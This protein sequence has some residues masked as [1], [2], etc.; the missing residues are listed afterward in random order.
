M[1][2]LF[3]DAP[4]FFFEVVKKS[5]INY[6][7]RQENLLAW[8][9]VLN[10]THY[11]P[12]HY[13]CALIDFYLAYQNGQAVECVD[14][15]FILEHNS[16]LCAV[17]PLSLSL[18]NQSIIISSHG[19]AIMPPLFTKDLPRKLQK[20]LVKMCQKVLVEFCHAV[21]ISGWKSAES[22]SG[23][24]NPALSEW[25]TQS[26]NLSVDISLGYDMFIDLADNI[27][28]IKSGFR[29][30]YK[31]LI[32]SG[33]RIWDISVVTQE[34]SKVWDEFQAF[35]V[36]VAGKETRC[37]QSWDV[38]H[39]A[40]VDNDAFLV[41]LR[42][43]EGMMVGAGFFSTTRDEGSYGVGV[44]NRALFDKPLGHVVQYRAIEEMQQRGI[45]WYK[46]GVMA[47]PAAEYT[48]KEV[49]I[50]HFKQGFSTHVFPRYQFSYST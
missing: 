45:R 12:T 28:Q 22:F 14:I 11:I 16:Q 8:Q 48:P 39:K 10:N 2:S 30:S 41:I 31:S 29:K 4:E 13:S 9:Q 37:V 6:L 43:K 40:I 18:K 32:N 15:S 27:T 44:Y 1:S 34:N 35:H 42:D 17:W 5:G 24:A 19:L 38:Q 36:A 50:S 49:S 7:K 25:Q 20:K 3:V 21:S 23:I 47:Y 26:M 46:V 33:V